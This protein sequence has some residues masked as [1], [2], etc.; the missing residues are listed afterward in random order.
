MRQFAPRRHRPAAALAG[1]LFALAGAFAA[2]P[3]HAQGTNAD[4][5]SD[6]VNMVI[7]YGDDKCPESHG[8]QITVCARKAESERYRIPEPFRNT[9]GPD[10][11]AWTNRVIAYERV[12]AAGTQSCSP[13]GAG[14]W[15]GCSGQFIKNAYAEKKAETD[16]NFQKMISDARAKRMEGVDAEAVETQ[17]RVEAAEKAYQERERARQDA[18]EATGKKAN[19]GLSEPLPGAQGK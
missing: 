2:L 8:D 12:G 15:T 18:A 4:G 13:V 14:G 6:K 11:E 17:K 5:G 3:A 9:S 1:A 16:V 10:N 19:D 7:I